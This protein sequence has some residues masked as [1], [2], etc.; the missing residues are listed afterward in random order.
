MSFWLDQMF[1]NWVGLLSMLVI[2]AMLGILG[3]FVHFFLKQSA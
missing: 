2:F 3:W 1:G